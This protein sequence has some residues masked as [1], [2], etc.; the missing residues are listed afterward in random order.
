MTKLMF[1]NIVVTANFLSL[2]KV[3]FELKWL[4]LKILLRESFIVLTRRDEKSIIKTNG[5]IEI[6]NKSKILKILKL[7]IEHFNLVLFDNI[8][9]LETFSSIFSDLIGIYR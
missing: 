1:K 3:F 6:F 5:I 9:V 7:C 4:V 8:V 2:I